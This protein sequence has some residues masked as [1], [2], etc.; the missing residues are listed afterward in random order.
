MTAGLWWLSCL[1]EWRAFERATRRVALTQ[2]RYLRELFHRNQNCGYFRAHR[3]TSWRDFRQQL[4]LVEYAQLQPWIE[5]RPSE[6]CSEPIRLFEPTSGTQALKLIPYTASLKRDFQR[7]LSPW[8]ADLYGGKPE[9]MRGRAYWA[10]TP[11]PQRMEQVQGIPVGFEDDAAY[12]SGWGQQLV[13]RMLA[14]PRPCGLDETLEHLLR[15]RDL[16]LV[17]VWSPSYWLLLLERLRQKW[18]DFASLPGLSQPMARAREQGLQALWPRLR[19]LSCWADGPSKRFLTEL[20][21]DFPD[22]F[23]QPKGLLATEAFVSFPLLGRAGGALALRSHFFEFL[24]SSGIHLAH[25]LC[26]GQTYEVVVSTGGGFYRYRLG[27][28]VSVRGFLNECPLLTFVGRAG[29]V[30]DHF[31]E[32]LTPEAV[33]LCLPQGS[34]PCFVAFEEDSYVLYASNLAEQQVRKAEQQLCSFYHYRLCREL[35]QL[36]P[37]RGY[38]L[39]SDNWEP[40]YSRLEGLGRRRGEVKV[41]SLRLEAD[42]SLHLPGQWLA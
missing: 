38:Q 8:I 12:L 39:S 11:P 20:R 24:D 17:S 27:D 4:P 13:R 16:N 9:L 30:S 2:E 6:L 31:G 40:F 5:Q 37:L 33:D 1:P 29:L 26:Q 19:L 23:I 35:G 18:T 15:C 7:G 3:L 32:K 36:Q 21:A 10:I 28:Q 34:G 14:V 41:A 42:W 22:L 25:Q